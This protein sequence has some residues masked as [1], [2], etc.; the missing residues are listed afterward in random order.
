MRLAGMQKPH[1]QND[2]RQLAFPRLS[3][4]SRLLQHSPMAEMEQVL[5]DRVHSLRPATG[6]DLCEHA[7]REILGPARSASGPGI[8]KVPHADLQ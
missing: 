2:L 7:Q 8:E 5:A 3:P 6:A 4:K 1:R